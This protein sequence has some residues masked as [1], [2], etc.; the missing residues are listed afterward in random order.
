MTSQTSKRLTSFYRPLINPC[1]APSAALLPD[2]FDFV[3]VEGSLRPPFHSQSQ[4]IFFIFLRS[5]WHSSDA[6][7]NSHSPF[8][9]SDIISAQSGCLMQ[10]RGP[11]PVADIQPVC[12]NVCVDWVYSLLSLHQRGF[13]SA[14]PPLFVSTSDLCLHVRDAYREEDEPWYCNFMVIFVCVGESVCLFRVYVW[15][16]S[17]SAQTRPQL[18]YGNRRHNLYVAFI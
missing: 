8:Q 1:S 9:L 7:S 13:I 15:Q 18:R 14:R 11:A 6:E 16:R 2:V 4:R 17:V 12:L 10:T 3:H 5:R